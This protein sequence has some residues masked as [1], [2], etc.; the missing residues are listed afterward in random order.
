MRY[1]DSRIILYRIYIFIKEKNNSLFFDSLLYIEYI[2]LLSPS[3]TTCATEY[4]ENKCV[5][6]SRTSPRRCWTHSRIPWLTAWIDRPN[7]TSSVTRAASREWL[8]AARGKPELHHLRSPSRSPSSSENPSV[9]I[10]RFSI[11]SPVQNECLT[12]LK[13]NL[14]SFIHHDELKKSR[15][16]FFRSERR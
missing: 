1:I 13:E 9:L 10:S 7:R 12:Y 2:S 6:S 15:I 5:P 16:L 4:E 8:Y 3:S 14:L 11:W